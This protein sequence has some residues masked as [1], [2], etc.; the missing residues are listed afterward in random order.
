MKYIAPQVFEGSFTC[1]HCGVISQQ[2]WWAIAWN[3][4]HYANDNNNE[5]RIGTC[6]HC[7]KN[8]FWIKDQMYYPDTGTAPFPN[9]EMPDIVL[10]LYNEA[11]SIAAKSP[12]GAA[13]LLRLAIQVLCKE[14][15]E[16]GT[17]INDDIKNLVAK[18][19]PEI[20]QQS[21][22]IVRVTGNNAV[23]PEQIDT[24]N[25]VVG[26]GQAIQS[27]EYHSRVY[28]CPA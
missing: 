16:K 5:L 26:C 22:D 1:P 3:E 25:P 8:T 19:L 20:V 9:I 14:L 24:D 10:S 2:T 17:N 21:L 6:T 11:A 12:R 4:S 28:D 18:G 23:H 13:A 15:G 27:L 7:N